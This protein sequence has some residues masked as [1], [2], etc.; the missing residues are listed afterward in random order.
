MALMGQPIHEWI[1][2]MRAAHERADREEFARVRRMTQE[3]RIAALQA[4]SLTAQ[5]L[6]EV[7]SPEA[8]ARALAQRDP[9]PES[10][11]EALRALRARAKHA[12]P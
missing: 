11:V 5:R 1:E 4:A 8:R 3:E 12:R 9:L 6:L 10:S 2:R 7:M